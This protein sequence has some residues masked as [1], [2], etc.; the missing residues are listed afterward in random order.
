MSLRLIGEGDLATV[1]KFQ[2][3]L[4]SFARRRQ[5]VVALDLS[6]LSF[7][8]ATGLAAIIAFERQLRDEERTLMLSHPN[9]MM[10]RVLDATG[11][12]WLLEVQAE[13]HRTSKSLHPKGATPKTTNWA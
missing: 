5:R 12:T 10:K 11:L 9:P 6:D 4:F 1:S 13:H 3:A 7:I 2:A 8:D